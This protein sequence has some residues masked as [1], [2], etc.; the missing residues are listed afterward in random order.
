MWWPKFRLHTRI[1]TYLQNEIWYVGYFYIELDTRIFLV[2]IRLSVFCSIALK[3]FLVI[4][5]SLYRF[6]FEIWTC[7][8]LVGSN[9]FGI[10]KQKFDSE[11]YIYYN[12]PYELKEIGPYRFSF[13]KSCE[14]RTSSIIV[15]RNDSIRIYFQQNLIISWWG[16][17]HP[18]IGE[19]RNSGIFS[20]H[21]S[22]HV[23]LDNS[24]NEDLEFN[25]QRVLSF[26]REFEKNWLLGNQE[27]FVCTFLL[28]REVSCFLQHNQTK[29]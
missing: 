4:A 28:Q 21:L 12:H 22:S 24:K 29:H 23:H 10:T 26:D 17:I 3:Q 14:D 27:K 15:M 18:Q 19:L 11:I 16:K 9:F 25:K 20:S 5:I 1:S 13:W 2:W 6:K 8:L 7:I